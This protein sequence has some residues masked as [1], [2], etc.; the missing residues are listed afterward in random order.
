MGLQFDPMTGKILFQGKEVGQYTYEN[1][2]GRVHIDVTYE[3][4]PTNWIV[5][6]SWFDYGL[7]L[8]LP[9]DPAPPHADLTIETPQ[10]GLGEFRAVARFLTEREI[11]AD[12]YVWRF[13]KTDVD[14]WPSP[15]HGH[16]YEHRVKLDV[17]TGYIYDVV[18]RQ[19]YAKMKDKALEAVRAQLRESKDFAERAAALLG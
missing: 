1:G 3:C 7:N 18:T 15:L 4:D 12:G 16:D 5:P 14:N 17:L 11:K 8:V 19:Q 6:L 13:H 10:D 9:D 2:R